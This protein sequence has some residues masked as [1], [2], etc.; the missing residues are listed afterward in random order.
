MA[1][2]ITNS[3]DATPEEA[4]AL[5]EAPQAPGAIIDLPSMEGAKEVI[6]EVLD[7]PNRQ[8]RENMPPLSKLQASG[9]D[10][11]YAQGKLDPNTEEGQANIERLKL[12]LPQAEAYLNQKSSSDFIQPPLASRAQAHE[13]VDLPQMAASNRSGLDKTGSPTQDAIGQQMLDDI[14][15]REASGENTA[16]QAIAERQELG[17][18]SA[19]QG[20]DPN[21]ATAE[22]N[23]RLAQESPEAAAFVG[24]TLAQGTGLEA[25]AAP[26]P[27]DD[28]EGAMKEAEAA[29]EMNNIMA[30][31]KE[32]GEIEAK[33]LAQRRAAKAE[34]T[35]KIARQKQIKADVEKQDEDARSKDDGT[36]GGINFGT[37][38]A[39]LLGGA[40]QGLIG[41]DNPALTML[42]KI[43]DREE[44][45]REELIKRGELSKKEALAQEK[46]QYEK[47][48]KGLQAQKLGAEVAD[49]RN[50][51]QEKVKQAQMQQELAANRVTGLNATQLRT[52]VPKDEQAFYI[53]NPEDQRF[54]EGKDK[55]LSKSVTKNLNE[56]QAALPALERLRQITDIID[57]RGAVGGTISKV[58]D[59]ELIGEADSLQQQAIGGLRVAIFGPGVITD[60]ER[61]IAERVIRNPMSI[62]S[63]T[64]ANRAV[65]DSVIKKVRTNMKI[66]MRSSVVGEFPPTENEKQV[67]R[68]QRLQPNKYPNTAKGR[69]EAANFLIRNGAWQNE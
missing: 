60:N 24:D 65:L 56:I 3:M 63:L 11:L 29:V 61:A 27:L 42:D 15:A 46:W 2:D 6:K 21:L 13:G 19:D 40:K 32:R 52:M 59:R 4:A 45:K 8:I 36:V 55:E 35:D 62:F 25:P 43:A 58:I 28:L 23:L 33:Q 20:I 17:M 14:N 49:L 39:I 10:S 1:D 50:G 41:G 30:E 48:L 54:Y 9:I 47:L 37:A 38:L 51:L 22:S 64:S 31:E 69:S 44:K 57:K 7:A 26:A 53:F 12:K 67:E 66:M 18:S 34:A 16:E 68:L 5:I